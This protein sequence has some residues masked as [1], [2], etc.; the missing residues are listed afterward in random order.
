MLYVEQIVRIY[1]VTICA[2]HARQT[3]SIVLCSVQKH[4]V[5]SKFRRIWNH[6]C[7][8]CMHISIFEPFTFRCVHPILSGKPRA[9]LILPFIYSN[10][11]AVS[12]THMMRVNLLVWMCEVGLFVQNW[13]MNKYRM[14]Y[15][16]FSPFLFL[17][18]LSLAC[19]FFC[20]CYM[21]A[22]VFS[23]LLGKCFVM[24]YMMVSIDFFG[25]LHEQTHRECKTMAC[26]PTRTRLMSM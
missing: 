1:F 19:L 5:T 15:V 16:Q 6:L 22:C 12:H 14:K 10:H 21:L 2:S 26:Q 23:S 25:S 8:T 13:T 24:P 18:L 17:W 9:F 20:A 4:I 11:I 3:H 7:K